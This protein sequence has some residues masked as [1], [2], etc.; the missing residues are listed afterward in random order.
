MLGLAILFIFGV[1][2]AI[3]IGV[4]WYAIR[5]ARKRGRRAWLWGCVAAFAM[6]NVM[7]WDL[8]PTLVMHEYYCRTQAGFWPYVTFEEWER[9]NPGVVGTLSARAGNKLNLERR[10]EV[11]PDIL[12]SWYTKR[13]YRD[14]RPIEL[15]RSLVKIEDVFIDSE[16]H[17]P[18]ARSLNFVRGLPANTLAAGGSPDEIRRSLVLGWGNR[19]CEVGGRPIRELFGLYIYDFWKSGEGK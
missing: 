16:S 2:V 13:F 7:F 1:Y 19:Q 18:I 11:P 10:D 9:E 5:W 14:S 15:T 12:R 8:V 4:T 6:Y 17:I 3:S